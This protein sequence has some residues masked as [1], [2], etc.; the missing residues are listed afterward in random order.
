MLASYK[1]YLIAESAAAGALVG[2]SELSNQSVS[3]FTRLNG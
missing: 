3:N 2:K 1:P